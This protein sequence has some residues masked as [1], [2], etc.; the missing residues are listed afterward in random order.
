MSSKNSTWRSKHSTI[1]SRRVLKE[2]NNNVDKEQSDKEIKDDSDVVNINVIFLQTS[3][4]RKLINELREKKLLESC[5]YKSCIQGRSDSGNQ[6][7]NVITKLR[8]QLKG[9][10]VKDEAEYSFPFPHNKEKYFLK[11]KYL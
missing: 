5:D 7:S 3:S 4:S 11:T 10:T 1:N 8:I 6:K 2:T 9:K